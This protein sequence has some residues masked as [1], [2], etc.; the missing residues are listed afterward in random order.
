MIGIVLTIL[1]VAPPAP[2]HAAGHGEEEKLKEFTEAW[3]K[4][5]EKERARIQREAVRAMDN[6]DKEATEAF[7]KDL[8]SEHPKEKPNV[9]QGAIEVSLWTIVVFVL[10]LLVLRR[11]A[12]GPI[13]EGLNKREESIARDRHEADLA[14]KEAGELRLALEAERERA[15]QEIK[16]M[17]DKAR[18]AADK[19][20]AE[21]VARVK[22][23]LQTERERLY[24]DLGIARDHALHEIWS[25][26]ANVAALIS[27]KVIK[28][29]LSD[30]DHRALV[31]EALQEFRAAGQERKES[32]EEA[33]G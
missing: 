6:K 16:G 17:F 11:F 12:W 3:K 25:Q 14:R 18:E 7:F 22:T 29:K 1:A 23:E 4:L 28:K 2:L 21:E 33:R 19:L 5:P 27:G 13:M 31:D 30:E 20:G 10:L 32:V 15:A 26:V 24:R 9:F 8:T